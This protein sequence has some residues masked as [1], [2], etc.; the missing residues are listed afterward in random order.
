MNWSP[1]R[2]KC[3]SA[4]APVALVA[5]CCCRSSLARHVRCIAAAASSSDFSSAGGGGGGTGAPYGGADGGSSPACSRARWPRVWLCI[6]TAAFSSCRIVRVSLR[7]CAPRTAPCSCSTGES[8]AW[9]WLSVATS[10]SRP[11]RTTR[12]GVGALSRTL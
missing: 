2:S 12:A 1:P 6:A 9:I 4:T 7:A 10:A 3:P 8:L 5:A 11:L